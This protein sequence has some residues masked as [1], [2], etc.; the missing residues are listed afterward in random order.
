MLGE[1]KTNIQRK[2]IRL[3]KDRTVRERH[4]INRESSKATKCPRT[5]RNRRV[6]LSKGG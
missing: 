3:K 6:D 4:T 2:V 1:T 5:T